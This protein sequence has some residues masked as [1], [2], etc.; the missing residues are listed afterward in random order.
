MR[1]KHFSFQLEETFPVTFLAQ[2]A[3]GGM[4]AAVVYTA[5]MCLWNEDFKLIDALFICAF[6]SFP[7][8]VAGAIKSIIMWAP[9]GLT[10]VRVRAITR[11]V[12]TCTITGLLALN[13]A[14]LAGYERQEDLAAWTLTCLL[15]G[16]P[17]AML[18][19]SR[20]KPW[21]LFIYGTIAGVRR[22][23]VWGTLGT[24]PL[25]FLSLLTLAVSCLYFA[26][27]ILEQTD[28]ISFTLASLAVATYL[29]F[30]AYL[31]FRSPRKLILCIAA[32][33]ANIPVGL[34]GY[35]AY[36][37]YSY[38]PNDGPIFIMTLCALFVTAWAGFLAARLLHSN[39]LSN[40]S[41]IQIEQRDHDC[42]GS[43][44]VEWQQ[45]VA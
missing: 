33:V 25:R 6:L 27:S 26:C 12:V 30:T 34:L 44:F 31:T 5:A 28:P 39:I 2:G 9:Y 40:T 38:R 1:T 23:S 32:L 36:Q 17:T 45:R 11:V 24:L 10:K 18:V 42:L 37:A 7:T 13:A 29:L 20:V 3:L 4:L 41:L 43:R 15:A 16:V 19:G 35:L 21:N 8:T 14:L 22:R